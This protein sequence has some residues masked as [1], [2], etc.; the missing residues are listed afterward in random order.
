MIWK[1]DHFS[2]NPESQIHEDNINYSSLEMIL[3]SEHKWLWRDPYLQLRKFLFNFS[4]YFFNRC[5]NSIISECSQWMKVIFIFIPNL[6]SFCMGMFVSVWFDQC[7]RK[8]RTKEIPTEM[9]H[10]LRMLRGYFTDKDGCW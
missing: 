6:N 5:S 9:L 1:W 8:G 4:V 10:Y 2:S 7:K 3:T